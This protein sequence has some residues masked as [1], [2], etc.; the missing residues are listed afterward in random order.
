MSRCLIIY[1]LARLET[2]NDYM[3]L[4]PKLAAG[5]QEELDSRSKSPQL[6]EMH[7]FRDAVDVNYQRMAI[8]GEELSG[9]RS[10]IIQ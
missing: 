6:V 3:C 4:S 1:G 10:F 2:Q 7:T 5:L 8:T 9:V